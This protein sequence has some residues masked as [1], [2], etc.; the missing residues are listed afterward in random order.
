MEPWGFDVDDMRSAMLASTVASA[1]GA[2][3]P[4]E[5]FSMRPKEVE[6]PEDLLVKELKKLMPPRMDEEPAS[7]SKARLAP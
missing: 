2:E 1:A 3:I 4:I 7:T 6:E 5:S